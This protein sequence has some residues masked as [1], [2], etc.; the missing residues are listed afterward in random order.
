M[1]EDWKRERLRQT[2]Q[3]EKEKAIVDVLRTLA[4][5]LREQHLHGHDELKGAADLIEQQKAA[6]A[7][8]RERAG[9]PTPAVHG[10]WMAGYAAA[11]RDILRALDDGDSDGS[12][13]D[14]TR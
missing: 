9:G 11:M 5:R 6:I 10:D 12:C 8:V 13:N 14:R 7:R 3:Q 1:T 2:I 4:E